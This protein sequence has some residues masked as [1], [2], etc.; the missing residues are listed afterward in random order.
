[1]FINVV[2]VLS[3]QSEKLMNKKVSKLTDEQKKILKIGV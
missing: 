1:M 2:T 3:D